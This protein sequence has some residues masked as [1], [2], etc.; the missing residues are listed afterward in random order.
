MK[1][2]IDIEH[3]NAAIDALDVA[4]AA[5]TAKFEKENEKSDPNPLLLARYEKKMMEI[6]FALIEFEDQL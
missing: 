4:L 6:G 5:A 3:V 2:N 1:L